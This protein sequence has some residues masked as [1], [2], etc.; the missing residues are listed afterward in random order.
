MGS[1]SVAYKRGKEEARGSCRR[2]RH[3]RG[4]K[5]GR[6]RLAGAVRCEQEVGGALFISVRGACQL[7]AQQSGVVH[8]STET[9]WLYVAWG[10]RGAAVARTELNGAP[11]LRRPRGSGLEVVV[12]GVGRSG[13]SG[14]GGVD[15]RTGKVSFFSRT[16]HG[17]NA[18]LRRG[19]DG[20]AQWQHGQ[21]VDGMD[22]MA[23]PWQLAL[24]CIVPAA[25]AR[26]GADGATSGCCDGLTWRQRAQGIVL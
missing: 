17:G 7:L 4:G 19:G 25:H 9:G 21:R 24:S 16:L 2:R 10:E 26:A 23:R 8:A 1:S 5:Q 14:V 20:S 15:K 13:G 6:R 12:R 18:G 11:W 22:G 3:E